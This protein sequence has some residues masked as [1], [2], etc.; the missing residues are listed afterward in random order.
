MSPDFPQTNKLDVDKNTEKV[1]ENMNE[2]AEE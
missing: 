1:A 2:L